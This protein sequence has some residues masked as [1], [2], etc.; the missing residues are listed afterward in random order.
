MALI[1]DPATGLF[2]DQATGKA[3]TDAAGTQLST[4]PG[5]TSQAQRSLGISNALYSKLAAFQ[6]QEQQAQAGQTQLG[7]ALDRTIKGTGPSVAQ[8]QLQQ[9]TEG[10]AQGQQ[11]QAAGATGTNAALARYAAMQNTA[12]AQ[13]QA[14]QSAAAIRAQEVAQAEQAK[15]QVL[16]QQG[17]EANTAYGST[18]A[19]TV[20]AGNT[21][22]SAGE[23]QATIDQKNSEDNKA[24]AG[25]IVNG[26]GSAAVVGAVKS[27]P[28]EKHD[29]SKISD[30]DFEKLA[31]RLKGFTFDY[32]HPGT[33]GEAPGHRA[34]VMADEVKKGGP[35]GK[36]MVIDGKTLS[37]DVPN[38]LGA[39]A[40][41]T[42]YL[43]QE[44]EKLKSKK[45]GK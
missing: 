23:S 20:G 2:V 27:D 13:A 44:I 3:F 41:L 6:Q 12:N 30:A 32:D 24:L 17:N 16:A 9:A 18:I 37:L 45:K 33:E 36:N 11:S 40:G 39:L 31:K 25:N 35:I 26:L 10:I 28:K 43:H 4:D 8:T 21:A 7:Q 5:L 22:A 1:Q 15:G 19:G 38:T 42:G 34:G 29:V 14:A